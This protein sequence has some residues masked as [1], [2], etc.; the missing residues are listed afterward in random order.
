LD[1]AV[2]AALK[3]LADQAKAV[4]W[5][6]GRRDGETLS[7]LEA[8]LFR[9]EKAL[10]HRRVKRIDL[11]ETI[12]DVM[13]SRLLLYSGGDLSRSKEVTMHTP[14]KLLSRPTGAR[15]LSNR[16]YRVCE[17]MRPDN[18]DVFDLPCAFGVAHTA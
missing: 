9:L 8:C 15:K 11:K 2:F 4:S 14:D 5:P 6:E 1:A 3:A 16:P 7:K 12:A 10:Q 13:C 17:I 18:V